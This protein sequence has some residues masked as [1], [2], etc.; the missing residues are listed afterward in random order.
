M[1]KILVFTVAWVFK[2]MICSDNGYSEHEKEVRVKRGSTVDVQLLLLG[3]RIRCKQADFE[4]QD[5]GYVE[6]AR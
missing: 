1:M 2:A 3:P 6:A 4:A 5:Y